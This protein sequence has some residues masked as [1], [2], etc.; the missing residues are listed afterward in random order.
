MH[1]LP[2]ESGVIYGPVRSR[3]LGISLG[4]NVL[5]LRRKV[6]SFDCVYCHYGPTVVPTLSP[7]ESEFP[8]VPEIV[9]AVERALR[10]TPHV[11][12]L[13]FSG[14]GEPT[15]HPYF[16]DVVLGVRRLR[17]RLNPQAR[18]SLFSNATMA[19]LPQIR[20]A[21]AHLDAPIMKLD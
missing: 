12:S 8:G 5:P 9:A 18:I 7:D 16:R 20:E 21:L 13:T 6:C 10:R 3:R 17:D 1:A 11:D 19:H 15:L 2:L 14:N 4:I